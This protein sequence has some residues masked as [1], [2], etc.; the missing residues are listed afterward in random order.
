MNLCALDPV[1]RIFSLSRCVLQAIQQQVALV[2]EAP[3]E[4]N[5]D[6]MFAFAA[7]EEAH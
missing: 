1:Y 6:N 3:F 2:E 7:A 4:P 5:Y